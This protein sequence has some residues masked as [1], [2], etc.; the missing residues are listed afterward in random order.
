MIQEAWYI[1]LFQ[2]LK[3]FPKDAFE[4]FG[5]TAEMTDEGLVAL[6]KARELAKKSL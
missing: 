2:R 5:E 3:E 4:L 1:A 6:A